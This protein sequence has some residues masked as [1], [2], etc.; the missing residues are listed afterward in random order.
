LLY[1]YILPSEWFELL[2]ATS[3]SL[4]F[5][6]FLPRLEST[7]ALFDLVLVLSP[8]FCLLED[9]LLD[10]VYGVDFL[11]GVFAG[12][13]KRLLVYLGNFAHGLRFQFF[14]PVY[15]PQRIDL[16]VGGEALRDRVHFAV[17]EG[18]YHSGSGGAF[19][20][21][22]ETGSH[23]ALKLGDFLLLEDLDFFVVRFWK[24]RHVLRDVD[25]YRFGLLLVPFFHFFFEFA[26]YRCLIL[27]DQSKYLLIIW[28][29]V[30]L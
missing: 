16:R 3:H 26:F 15:L 27:T 17:G 20:G 28:L 13:A 11:A 8:L 2:H 24:H 22:C 14:L 30:S 9:P 29:I 1:N 10:Q 12:H 25:L 7:D 21:A 19:L 5:F 6:C 23:R 4:L 18:G